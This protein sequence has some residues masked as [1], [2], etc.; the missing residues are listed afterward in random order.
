MDFI[1][2]ILNIASSCWD[3]CGRHLSFLRLLRK[4]LDELQCSMNEL[5]DHR[6]DVK[7]RVDA[8]EAQLKQRTKPVERWLK[9]SSVQ[10]EK[11]CFGGYYPNNCWISYKL[12]KKVINKMTLVKNHKGRGE[13][14]DVAEDP[15]PAS[16]Q[17]VP[18]YSTIG[19]DSLFATVWS[20][21]QHANVGIMGLY[22]MG[23]VGKTTLLK[24][25]NNEFAKTPDSSGFHFI[26]WLVISEDVKLGA[27]QSEIGG[28][29]GLMWPKEMDMKM[30]AC[31]LFNMLRTKQFVILLDDIWER[32]DLSVIGIPPP[33]SVNKSKILFTTRSEKV[34]GLMEADKKIR[35][36]CLN[37]DQSWELFQNKVGEETLGSS[38]EIQKLAESIAR[39]CGGLPLALVVIGRTMASKKTPGEWKHA[40]TTLH[41]H[42]AELSGM[43]D[44][45]FP[46][47]KF[48]YDNLSNDS[49]RLCFLFCS[50][51]PEDY[52]IY[53]LSIIERWIRMGYIDGF[54]NVQE[55]IDTGDD[56]VG[57]LKAACLLEFSERKKTVKM[58]DVIRDLAHWIVR[59]CGGDNDKLLVNTGERIIEASKP[60]K[61]AKAQSI[62]MM[63]TRIT[64]LGDRVDCPRLTTLLLSHN[65]L[66]QC[67][68]DDFFLFMPSLRF[69][70]LSYNTCLEALPPSIGELVSLEYLDLSF[71]QLKRK[72][73]LEMKKLIQMKSLFLNQ[74]KVEIPLGVIENLCNLQ[75]LELSVSSFGTHSDLRLAG[76]QE[77]GCL[78]QLSTL[79]IKISTLED[80]KTFLD[81]GHLVICTRFLD[82]TEL[83]EDTS[84]TLSSSSPLSLRSMKRLQRLQILYCKKMMEL[85][86]DNK[87][88]CSFQC[89]EQIRFVNVPRLLVSWDTQTSYAPCFKNLVELYFSGCDSVVDLTWIHLA[90]NLQI[91]TVSCCSIITEIISE[92]DSVAC[93]ENTLSSLKSIHLNNLP[94]LKSIY[95]TCLRFPFLNEIR[96]F[97]CS[98]LK[99]LPLNS[100]NARNN[101]M[102]AIEGERY[103]WN[104][105]EWENESI[106]SAFTPLFSI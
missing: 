43:G 1:T 31:E 87:E 98:Q 86:I 26:F 44:E 78:T 70:D 99:R 18:V 81:K 14:T 76:I 97:G 37:W 64:Q 28:R 48:S 13:F 34:C 88:T 63:N 95:P 66:L 35:V 54:D 79:E 53:S 9:K 22:G 84:L 75:M 52:E 67:I 32:I 56:I 106:K 85:V 74:L 41:K 68:S 45:V 103:W 29:L 91:L 17:M 94:C 61:W 104:N 83:D 102:Q 12:G 19:L 77:L 51:Y 73:P 21:L 36:K 90:P 2:P 6:D 10:L 46:I 82:I 25:I 59:E 7:G 33:D 92:K 105:L 27:I 69:L 39:K 89:L 100:N 57:S 42:A 11:R 71:T 96:V 62:S 24:K 15:P 49:I 47:L 50:L 101:K 58:H 38:R 80:L 20:S 4:N 5:K 8:A 65:L 3:F 30:R 40:I 72:L 60:G 55:A 93:N 23:G 16:V